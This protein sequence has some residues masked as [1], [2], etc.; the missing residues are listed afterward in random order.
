MSRVQ[1]G[2]ARISKRLEPAWDIAHLFPLQGMWSESEYLMLETNRLVEYSQGFIEVLPVPTTSH[3]LVVRFLFRLLESFVLAGDQGLVLFA[4]IR[5]RLWTGEFR[6]P[7][8][9]F[10]R[11]EHED[12]IGNE[13]WEGAD[14]V[15]E[16]VSGGKKD[17]ERDLVDKRKE[18]ARARIPEYWIVDPK[19]ETITVLRLA[20]KRYAV[21]GEFNKGAVATSCLLPGFTVDVTETFAQQL[22][23]TSKSKRRPAR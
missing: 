6:E 23:K 9:V 19:K 10:M 4:G 1:R 21:H 17:R 12:R 11:K 14:L 22:P 5:V 8:I 15:M 20:G 2:A 13:F 16:V 3:H 7:D 18:Y